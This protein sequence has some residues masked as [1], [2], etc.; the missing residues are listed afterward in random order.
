MSRRPRG[1][2]VR[3]HPVGCSRRRAWGIEWKEDP[4]RDLRRSVLAVVAV[5]RTGATRFRCMRSPVDARKSTAAR[6]SAETWCPAR[7]QPR[8]WLTTSTLCPSGSSTN[9]P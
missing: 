4:M 3:G 6:S 2:R 9:A 5:K 8:L 7:A 1:T